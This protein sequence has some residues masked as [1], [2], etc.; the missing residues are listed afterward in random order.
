MFK[1][2]IIVI[3]GPTA[4]GKTSVSIELSKMTDIEIISADSRQIYK[5]LDIG[6]AKPEP[7]EREAVPHHF[8]DFL[9]P[10]QDYSAGKFGAEAEEVV[11]NLL[12]N[13]KIPVV[14]GGSGLYIKALC[15]GFIEEPEIAE[16]RKK[17]VRDKL[18]NQLEVKGIDFLYDKLK[19]VDKKSW[20]KYSDKNPRRILRA[21]EFYAMTGRKFSLEHKAQSS[22]KNF[23]PLYFG[24]KFEREKLYDRINKR[25]EMMWRNGLIEETEM[26]LEMGCS[27]DLNSLNTVGYKECIA[28]LQGKMS[29]TDAIEE[30]KKNTRRFA[31]RQLTWFSRV[32]GMKWLEGSAPEIAEKFYD[33]YKNKMDL[34]LSEEN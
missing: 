23:E 15:E 2:Y 4:S 20:E 26:V 12:A 9:D 24:I 18:E 32:E 29:K 13:K 22:K 31:K 14:V 27:P 19:K 30:M 5:Y 17:Q 21:L 1:P 3:T 16:E 10:A 34:R 33:I 6:T 25:T 8:V 28:Y 11:E 7:E